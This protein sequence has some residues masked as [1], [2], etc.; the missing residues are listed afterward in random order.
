MTAKKD[1]EGGWMAAQEELAALST[2]SDHRVV[3]DVTH[4]MVTENQTAAAQSSRAI[5]DVVNSVRTGTPV[6]G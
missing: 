5:L 4:A 3:A 1:A 2:N 6:A